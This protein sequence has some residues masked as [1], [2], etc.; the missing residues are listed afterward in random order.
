L[1]NIVLAI[2]GIIVVIFIIFKFG[3]VLIKG[4]LTL[5]II[6]IVIVV[7]LN[8]AHGKPSLNAETTKIQTQVQQQT[9]NPGL[10]NIF[11]KLKGMNTKQVETYLKNSQAELAKHGISI[12]GVKKAWT[13]Y[14]KDQ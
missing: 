1:T 2:L 5:A 7:I 3:K 6:A 10:N 12:D 8:F 4:I 11:Q 14:N 9:A 13:E